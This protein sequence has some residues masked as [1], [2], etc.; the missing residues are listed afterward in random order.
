MRYDPA[1]WPEDEHATVQREFKHNWKGMPSRSEWNSS[2]G[3]I[4]CQTCTGCGYRWNHFDFTYDTGAL[5]NGKL[6]GPTTNQLCWNCYM[7]ETQPRQVA[8]WW[9]IIDRNRSPGAA[10][11]AKDAPRLK[12][13]GD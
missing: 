3:S 7:V 6:M 9:D 2:P 11:K 8:K 13:L 5:L 1:S 4:G 12:T 10:A